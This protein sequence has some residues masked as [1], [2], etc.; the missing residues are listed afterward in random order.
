[1]GHPGTIGIPD[2]FGTLPAGRSQKIG[3]PKRGWFQPCSIRPGE[4][5]GGNELIILQ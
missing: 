5:D 1:M 3:C 2:L 4:M